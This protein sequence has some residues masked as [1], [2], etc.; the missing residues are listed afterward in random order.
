MSRKTIRCL[1]GSLAA[2]L[3]LTTTTRAVVIQTV[4]VGSPNN[5]PG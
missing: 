1:L 5:A 4:P 3:L 2:A